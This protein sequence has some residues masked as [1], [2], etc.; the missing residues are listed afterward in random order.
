MTPRRLGGVRAS[1]AGR[2]RRT[3]R[4]RTRTA[5][6]TADAPVPTRT[7][8]RNSGERWVI[9]NTP[10]AHV[11]ASAGTS[12]VRAGQLIEGKRDNRSRRCTRGQRGGEQAADCPC[13]QEH[14][15]QN[16]FS[17]RITQAAPRCHLGVHATVRMLLPLPGSSGTKSSRRRPAGRPPRSRESGS[18][19]GIEL[20]GGRRPSP[21]RT[22]ARWR[23]QAARSPAPG[24]PNR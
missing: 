5:T 7:E 1:D 9:A 24:T 17:R 21:G 6:R 23:R 18:R 11:S 12:D 19:S 20:S 2:V 4:S 8:R 15:G 22:P 16:G 3:R 13:A 10:A 14:R